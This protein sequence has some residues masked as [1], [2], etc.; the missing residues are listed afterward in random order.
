MN[1]SL[2]FAAMAAGVFTA[3]C[4]GNGGSP[5]PPSMT[6]P[7]SGASGLRTPEKAPPGWTATA[8]R[9]IPEKDL[10]GGASAKGDALPN[11]KPLHVVV[12]L[13]MRNPAGARE[14]VASQYSP[15]HASYRKWL[16]PGEFTAMYNPTAAQAESVASYLRQ[17]GFTKVKIDSNRLI[18]SGFASASRAETAFHTSIRG[19]VANG[20]AVYGNVTPAF[21]P[22]KFHGLVAAVLGLSNAYQMHVHLL[23]SQHMRP[24][25]A[26]TPPPCL[27]VVNGICIGGEYGPSQYQVAYDVPAKLHTGAKTAVAVMAEG[28]VTQVEKDLRTAEKFWALPHVPY[29]VVPVGSPSTDTSGLDEWDLDTQIST[30]MAE[31]VSQLY[32]YDTT[33]LGDSDITLEYSKWVNDNLT[34]AGNSSFGEAESFAY[35]DGSMTLDDQLL[36]E[37]AAQGQTMF[38]STGDNGS[39]CPVLLATGAPNSGAPEVCYPASSPYVVAVGGTTLD[40]NANGT[41]PGTYYGEYVWTGTG[42]GYS[43]FES[44]PYWQ[45]N[46]ICAACTSAG[47]RAI[48]DIAMCGDN[49]G[50][51]MDVFVNATQEGVGGTS[52]SSPMSMGIWARLETRFHN[53]LGFAAP[54]YY[55]VYGYYEPCPMGSTTCVPSG[56]PGDDTSAVPPDTT[57]PIGGFHDILYGS[58]GIPNSAAP[59]WDVPSGLGTFD[60]S[61]MLTDL[62]NSIF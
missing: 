57:A 2:L 11:L 46:G 34:Q 7:G 6:A 9:A 41:G 27:E 44:P 20:T 56:E 36:N 12:G 5:L 15:G 3:A 18:V 51:P 13:Y 60:F 23:K 53:N 24:M 62:K 16:S 32:V 29:S 30:G 17:Q 10:A 38:A 31:R 58:N 35:T 21:V 49:N 26:G 54:V 43:A 19:T 48:A 37:A 28:D 59:G 25:T 1:K 39:G 22:A 4:S 52:L 8:T 33:S 55:G 42:G 14:L 50:C 45:K 61:V 40:T 47:V